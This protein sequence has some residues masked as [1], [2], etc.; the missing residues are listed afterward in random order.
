[1]TAPILPRDL[2][3]AVEAVG[4]RP[5]AETVRRS[6]LPGELWTPWIMHLATHTYDD[7]MEAMG[8]DEG[9]V[10][11]TVNGEV[12]ASATMFVHGLSVGFLLGVYA[13]RSADST[14]PTE[15][16]VQEAPDAT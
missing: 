4:G 5:I 2:D 6:G 14:T 7:A 9:P 15:V 16:G 13:A 1:M 8:G 10:E 12:S 3:A 11:V